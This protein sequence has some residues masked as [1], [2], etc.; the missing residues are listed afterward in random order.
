M[1]P[2]EEQKMFAD[3]RNRPPDESDADRV[4]ANVTGNVPPPQVRSGLLPTFLGYDSTALNI[5]GPDLLPPLYDTAFDFFGFE[6]GGVVGEQQQSDENVSGPVG[7]VGDVPEAVSEAGTVADDVPMEVEEGTYILNAAAVEFAGSK[8]I[9]AMLLDAI[10]EAVRQGVDMEPNVD[11]I[12]LDKQVSLLVSKG[13]VVIPPKIAQIIGYDRL[14]KINNRGKQETE[15]RVQENG[16]SP[17]AEALDQQAP[18]PANDM[19]MAKGGD[20]SA[21]NKIDLS[22]IQ[23]YKKFKDPQASWLNRFETFGAGVA[24]SLEDMEKAVSYSQQYR[25]KNNTDDSYEDTMRHTLLGGL[26]NPVAGTYADLKEGFH[27]YLEGYGKI[28]YEKAKELVTGKT[29]NAEQI[30]IARSIIKESEIDLNNNIYGRELRRQIPDETEYVRAVES[31]MDI[32]RSKGIDAVPSITTE[33][34]ETLKL[35]LSIAKQQQKMAPGGVATKK[36]D[37]YLRPDQRPE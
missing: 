24:L 9:K 31:L 25:E 5:A 20:T 15:K 34:G 3:K 35:Q 28:A 12:K 7:F 4:V 17:E 33:D 30:D 26:Y 18:N 16:Q 10:Q 6:D 37:R 36:R 27:K 32:A 13:E 29:A 2:Q 14:E 1:S 23:D 8:D 19:A 22:D 11:K 21:N